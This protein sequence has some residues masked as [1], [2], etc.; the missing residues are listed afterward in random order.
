MKWNLRQVAS[1]FS[2]F[3]AALSAVTVL[4]G[5]SGSVFAGTVTI[6]QDNFH[7]GAGQSLAAQAPQVDH[8]VSPTWTKNFSS[9]HNYSGKGKPAGGKGFHPFWKANGTITGSYNVG[10]SGALE[11]A[12]LNFRPVPGHIYTLTAKVFPRAYTPGNNSRDGFAAMGFIS[13]SQAAGVPPFFKGQGPWMLSKFSGPPAHRNNIV[14]G[15]FGP[16]LTHGFTV[17]PYP[18]AP[19]GTLKI[20][21]N[22]T[23]SHWV[24][25]EYY[26]GVKKGGWP[27]GGNNGTAN[28]TGI[29][30]VAIGV[31]GQSARVTYF[32][33]TDSADP[34]LGNLVLPKMARPYPTFQPK[35]PPPAR[36]LYVANI[37]QLPAD[38]QRLLVTLQG[39]VNRTQPRIYL[40]WGGPNGPFWLRQ[41]E[42]QGSTGR[43]IQVKNPLS[44]VKIFRSAIHGAVV[45]DPKVYISP[46]IAV[47]VATV[48]NLVVATPQLA[49]RLHLPIKV[50]LR[51][52]FKN[53]VAA[54]RYL[55]TKLVPRM[56]PFLF[57]CLAPSILGG[58]SEDQI[59]AARGITFWVTGPKEQHEPGANMAGE[60]RQIEKLFAA[61]PLMGVVRGFW[62]N[63]IGYGLGEGPGVKLGS[64]Y[65]KVT[66]VSTQVRNFSVLS[67]VPLAALKQKFAPAPKLNPSKVY[68]SLTISDGDNLNTWDDFFRHWFKSPYH[69]K[70]AVG[71]AMGPTL[72]D[73]APTL[74]RWYYQHAGP[75]DEFLAGVSGLGYMYPGVWAERLHDR[76]GALK[77]FYRWTWRYMRRMD[78]K[79][80]RLHQGYAL[81]FRRVIA[82]VAA[83]LPHVRFLMPDY[84]WTGQQRVTYVLP[85]GQT[86]FRAATNWTTDKA[87]EISHL[88]RQIR[89]RAGATRPAFLNVFV[90]NWFNS[91]HE[92]HRLLK[93]LGSGYV[94]VT[95]SQLNTLYRAYLKKVKVTVDFRSPIPV[96]TGQPVN[97]VGRLRNVSGVEQQVGLH[98]LAGLGHAVIKPAAM[99]LSRGQA[100]TVR[101]Q[102]VPSGG[103][104]R[105]AASGSFGTRP[106]PINVES[107]AGSEL[108]QPLPPM[109]NL[110]PVA[111]WR[112]QGLKHLSGS[113]GKNGEW[114]ARR[115]KNAPGFIV[116]GPYAKLAK[117]RYVALFRLKRLSA[118]SGLVATLDTCTTVGGGTRQTA[119]RAVSTAALPLN[120]WRWFPL[121]FT[122]PGG[123]VQTRV[124]WSGHA[125][126]AVG[127]AAVFRVAK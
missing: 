83:D 69:G 123:V 37:G 97:V 25:T 39:V 38:Q 122:H 107:I 86:V 28:P 58:G 36:H 51:G 75:K 56:N 60:K 109:G 10:G 33:L 20:V 9:G 19:G 94:D 64:E 52:K 81:D 61:T 55:R 112:G 59:I 42:K 46:D 26:N 70:F 23:Q 79:T 2:H 127:A 114:V 82:T 105:L 102:G 106:V 67:G 34:P 110:S 21:L 27:Y 126:L 77:T 116:Y 1:L 62:W 74:A 80:L 43:P 118:G 54:L 117:G 99:R 98:V 119:Q 15:Y 30:E 16:G 113:V 53:D 11:V 90:V 72:I 78:M 63:G 14:Q 124:N 73:V 108:V 5:L 71:W 100:A 50:D 76:S 44:L 65:G 93:T 40:L 89:D 68:I 96:I 35:M 47:D 115:G 88:A 91:M 13:G 29:T 22:T 48:D 45:P 3:V 6:Y 57:T 95:P 85:S 111:Y 7:G 49:K 121:A 125:S 87:R 31:N 17:S 32:R 41:M 92:L 8:G 101:L 120:K 66:V 24:A 4:V 84:S 18:A 103:P 104:I 12:G